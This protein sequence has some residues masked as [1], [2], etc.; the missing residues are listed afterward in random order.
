MSLFQP[1]NVNS[2]SDEPSFVIWK[3]PPLLR[4]PLPKSRVFTDARFCATIRSRR[5]MSLSGASAVVPC[6]VDGSGFAALRDDDRR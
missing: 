5:A 1:K 2:A 6:D 4:V 3:M